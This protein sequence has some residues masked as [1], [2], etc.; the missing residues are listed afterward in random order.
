MNCT[1]VTQ[2]LRT[3]LDIFSCVYESPED[4][5]YSADMDSVG[6][7]WGLG[8]CIPDNLSDDAM[9]VSRIYT[10]R[11]K[12]PQM[13]ETGFQVGAHAPGAAP[14]MKGVHCLEGS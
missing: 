11:S 7:G 6:L 1:G 4:H 8:V 12:G 2:R 14:P 3:I 9:L 13:S 5:H 10:L